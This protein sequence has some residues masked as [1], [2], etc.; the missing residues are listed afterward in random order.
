MSDY[1]FMQ[2][3]ILQRP[4]RPLPLDDQKQMLRKIVALMKILLAQAVKTAERFVGACGRKII[5]APD[6]K[7]A[8]KYEAHEFIQRDFDA[9]FFETLREEETHTYDTDDEAEADDAAADEAD[10]DDDND[11]ADDEA[12]DDDEADGD[13]A[14]DIVS[15]IGV[16]TNEE[17]EY[18]TACISSDDA[19]VRFHAK[20]MQYDATWEEWS[21]DDPYLCL[22][23]KSIDNVP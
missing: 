2:S 23:K 14:D 13:E 21:P 3:G 17:E 19:L 16:V 8:L 20:V 6:I 1:S 18:S 4:S 7:L 11:E 12:D 15:N 9:E 10:D 5:A 22:L